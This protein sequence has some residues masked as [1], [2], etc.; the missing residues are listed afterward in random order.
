[1]QKQNYQL[2]DTLRWLFKVACA[3]VR[4]LMSALVSIALL[5]FRRALIPPLNHGRHWGNE[6]RAH[7]RGAEAQRE[8]ERAETAPH[9]GL[10]HGFECSTVTELKA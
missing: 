5:T 3:P 1:M 7:Q 9:A 10:E 2:R 4:A 8:P 6:L